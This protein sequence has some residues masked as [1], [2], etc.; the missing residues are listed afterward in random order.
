[1]LRI[2][3]VGKSRFRIQ[4]SRLFSALFLVL[5]G[6][7]P[8]GTEESKWSTHQRLTTTPRKLVNEE[9]SHKTH[10]LSGTEA[11]NYLDHLQWIPSQISGLEGWFPLCTHYHLL[12][13]IVRW[14][15][16]CHKRSRTLSSFL[17][18]VEERFFL[19]VWSTTSK[20]TLGGGCC[21]WSF[22]DRRLWDM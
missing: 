17:H 18:C 1:M 7:G 2:F 12:I 3:V 6:V 5:T 4:V 9:F 14:L 20:R 8:Q 16:G 15:W 22:H 19:S 11:S 10:E 21:E 13:F